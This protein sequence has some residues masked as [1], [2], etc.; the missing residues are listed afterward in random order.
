MFRFKRRPVAVNVTVVAHELKPDANYVIIM[1]QNSIDTS[2]V[3][4][5]IKSLRRQGIKNV[6]AFMVNGST[7]DVIQE[8]KE[9]KHAAKK[10]S[11]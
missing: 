1:D 4:D 10:P 5:V 3:N 11:H 8:I 7:D 9:K 6:V 2:T